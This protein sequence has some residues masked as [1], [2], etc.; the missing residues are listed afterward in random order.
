LSRRPSLAARQN[1]PRDGQHISFLFRNCLAAFTIEPSLFLGEESTGMDTPLNGA[2]FICGCMIFSTLGLFLIR[3][4]L[5]IEWLKRQHEVA[6]FFFLM[7]GTLYA[8]LI[9]FAIFVVWGQFQDAGNNLEQEAN[10]VGN[11]SRMSMVMPEPLRTNIRN[12]LL[13]Y[14]NSVVKDEFPAMADGHD[15]PRTW[16]AAQKLWDVYNTVEPD[17]PRMQIYYSE[18]IKQLNQ[19]SNSRRI[20]LFTNRGTVPATLWYLLFIGGVMLIIFTWFFGHES[21]WSQAAM[22]AALAGVL[23]FSL[24]LIDSFDSPY[25]GVVQVTPAPFQLELVHITARGAM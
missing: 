7:I 13:N 12:A 6:S 3:R 9:A 5:N 16:D 18:S 17:N 19:L 4:H 10:E 24:F 2:I 23:A 22:T 14:L 20:R 8:V 25:S 21:V 11:L 15:S 1:H